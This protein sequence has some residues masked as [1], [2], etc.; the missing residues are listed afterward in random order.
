MVSNARELFPDPETPVITTNLLRGILVLMFFRLFSL[1][2]LTMIFSS[3]IKDLLL[4]LPYSPWRA[5]ILYRE[6]RYY[7]RGRN[8]AVKHLYRNESIILL[9]DSLFIHLSS[10][11]Q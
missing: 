9:G 2:P 7:G 11:L 1:A 4:G 3:D 5:D 8:L 10:V 6:G